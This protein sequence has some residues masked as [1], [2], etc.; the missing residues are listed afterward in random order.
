MDDREKL[1]LEAIGLFVAASEEI[2]F[3]AENREQLYG[4]V[5]QV[6]VGLGYAQQGK[7][8]QH[9]L[10]LEFQ[11]YKRPEYG[12]LHPTDKDLSV[13]TPAWQAFLSRICT[14]CASIHATAS[15]F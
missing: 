12:R 8:T 3:E 6:L 15:G 5:E 7:E 1:I 2:R 10:E 11:I 14:T 9:I 13:G 4:W